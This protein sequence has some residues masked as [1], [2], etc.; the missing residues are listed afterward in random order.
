MLEDTCTTLAELGQNFCK[1]AVRVCV[2]IGITFCSHQ[3]QF[4][5][6]TA[7][8][9]FMYNTQRQLRSVYNLFIQV[10]VQLIYI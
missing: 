8:R 4:T 2:S 10:I 9:T 5:F 1:V 3:C 7:Q 6:N